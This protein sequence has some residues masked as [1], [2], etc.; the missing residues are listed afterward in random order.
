M[1]WDHKFLL[2]NGTGH[3][4]GCIETMEILLKFS[5]KGEQYNLNREVNYSDGNFS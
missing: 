2:K 1:L 4:F 3:L 5:V